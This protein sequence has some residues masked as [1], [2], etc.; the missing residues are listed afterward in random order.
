M[1]K[2]FE[3]WMCRKIREDSGGKQ[4]W[5]NCEVRGHH[6]AFYIPD[7]GL[8]VDYGRDDSHKDAQLLKR[9]FTVLR[10]AAPQS[11]LEANDVRYAIY[12]E[13]KYRLKRAE[14]GFSTNPLGQSEQER[15][16]LGMDKFEESENPRK[17][18]AANSVEKKAISSEPK[19][20]RG[21]NVC[22]R[23]VE[24][25]EKCNRQ[26]FTDKSVAESTL[27]ALREFGVIGEVERCK[28]CGH[29]HILEAR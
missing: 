5:T 1:A 29:V 27:R 22:A 12:S 11:Q 14:R 21:S 19:T 18:V 28:I 17:T 9:G 20:I 2:K 6:V 13:L 16:F 23:L 25:V 3:R 10:F 15:G 24:T 4:V 7:L 8:C 26:V